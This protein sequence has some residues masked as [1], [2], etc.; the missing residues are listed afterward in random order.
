MQNC[1]Y[2]NF[3][4]HNFQPIFF[5][6]GTNI[7]LSDSFDTFVGLNNPI[8]FTSVGERGEGSPKSMIFGALRSTDGDKR[9]LTTLTGFF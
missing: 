4:G 5:Q 6:F 8:V 3:R 2:F 1:L 9:R 7:P